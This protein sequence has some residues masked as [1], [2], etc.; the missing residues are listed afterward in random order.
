MNYDKLKDVV[1]SCEKCKELLDQQMKYVIETWALL[2]K[3]GC[4]DSKKLDR[5]PEVVGLLCYAKSAF[6]FASGYLE[7]SIEISEV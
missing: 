4:S 3:S 1:L 2:V 5:F 7:R 6:S